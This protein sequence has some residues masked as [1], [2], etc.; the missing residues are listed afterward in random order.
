M[1][2][3]ANE[4][5]VEIFMN[6]FYALLLSEADRCSYHRAAKD[7]RLALLRSRGRRSR[8]TRKVQLSDYIVP[9]LYLNR[10]LVAEQ[11]EL[12]SPGKMIDFANTVA[13]DTYSS[14]P[15]LPTL[16][17]RDIDMFRAEAQLLAQ[18]NQKLLLLHGEGGCGKTTLL[19]Y[20][21]QW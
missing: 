12:Q 10:R 11:V 14:W 4:E 7:A 8:L 3:K 6:T 18:P 15:E 2:F 20:A 19:K 1:S 16:L 5:C 13:R 9:V 21:S 17:G